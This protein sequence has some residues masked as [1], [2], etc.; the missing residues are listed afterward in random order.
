MDI[1]FSSTP[2]RVWGRKRLH[3]HGSVFR[4]RLL[5]WT[6]ASPWK[7][8]LEA[9][10]SHGSVFWKRLWDGSVSWKRLGSVFWKRLTAME[11]SWKRL[12]EVP[13]GSIS[14]PRK[15][16]TATE[17][18]PYMDRKAQPQWK[19]LSTMD[20]HNPSRSCARWCSD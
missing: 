17:A 20:Q 2:Q 5:I 8:L 3:S 13:L 10:H 15:R 12:L 16:L 14:Q 6:E 19:C 4:K 9:S 18:S 11:T 1:I 7:C